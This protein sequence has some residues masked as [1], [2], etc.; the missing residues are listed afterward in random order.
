MAILADLMLR[1]RANSAE[2]QTGLNTAKAAMKKTGEGAKAFGQAFSKAFDEASNSLDRMIPGFGAAA[3]GVK[4]T[5]QNVGQLSKSMN[6][7]KVAIASTGIGLLVIALGSLISYFK[8]TEAGADKF[9]AAMNGI[10]SVIS[11][12]MKSINGLGE[13]ITLLL[14]GDFK[15]A[16]D[17]AKEAFKG[18]GE[19][20]KN[21]Y[22]TGNELAMRADKLGEDRID[23]LVREQELM[24]KIARA[25]EI[26]NDTDFSI[27]ERKKAA[28]EAEEASLELFTTKKKFA[29]EELDIAIEQNKLRERTYDRI[30]EENQLRVKV[31]ELEEEESGQMRFISRIQVKL[32]RELEKETKEREKALELLKA[33]NQAIDLKI[34]A[35]LPSTT[36]VDSSKLLSV[37]GA[38]VVPAPDMSLAETAWEDYKM[39]TIGVFEAIEWQALESFNTISNSVVNVG[40]MMSGALT[41][42]VTGLT[43]AFGNLF[44]GTEAGFKGVVTGALQAIQQIINALLAQAIAGVIAGESK[45]GLLGLITASMGIAALL[46]LWKSKVPEFAAGGIVSGPTLG[47]I[48]EYAGASNNPEVIAP[49]DKLQGILGNSMMSGDVTFRIEG[50]TLVGVLNNQKRKINSYK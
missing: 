20:M 14:K 9:A 21:A 29:Q 43:T 4:L 32:N 24:N 39:G 12:V 34:Q 37:T 5:I 50:T 45:K 10:K 22:T 11:T 25:R 17:R 35:V 13:A 41:Q 47:L 6:V 33:E 7:L 36:G 18:M 42:A 15:G 2:L 31:L 16:A 49:L 30:E 26:A 8:N 46:A 38:S 40:D 44:A 23:F 19:E 48:G 1:L 27:A 28:N 3:S